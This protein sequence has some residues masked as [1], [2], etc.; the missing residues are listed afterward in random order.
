MKNLFTEEAL[1]SHTPYVGQI[2]QDAKVKIDE[3]GVTAA[4][5]TEIEVADGAAPVENVLE[6]TLDSPFIYAITG[7]DGSILFVGTVYDLK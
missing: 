5:F 3:E 2:R 1:K 4:A 7:K 6:F